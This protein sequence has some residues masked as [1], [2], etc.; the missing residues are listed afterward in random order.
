MSRKAI[1]QIKQILIYSFPN[2]QCLILHYTKLLLKENE[3][4][5]FLGQKRQRIEVG[6]YSLQESSECEE[7]K[8]FSYLF[9]L[10]YVKLT[11]GGV[12]NDEELNNRRRTIS[13]LLTKLPKLETFSIYAMPGSG[14]FIYD[15]EQIFN[16]IIH[17][18]NQDEMKTKYETKH[19]T[20]RSGKYL[21][22][23]QSTVSGSR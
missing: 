1:E 9:N 16:S 6:E 7:E 13:N 17:G 8:D 3:L 10:K 4:S 14:C 11:Y 22:F 18:L 23:I 20:K 21:W 19:E 12:Y 15:R 5:L 2:L